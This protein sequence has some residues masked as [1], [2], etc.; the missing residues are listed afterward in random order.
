MNA[1][2][3]LR[4][5]DAG[6]LQQ[7]AEINRVL[8]GARAALT[9]LELWVVHPDP[10]PENLP[11]MDFPLAGIR[12][13]ALEPIHCSET[14]LELLRHLMDR[15]P[16]D[17]VLFPSSGW[18]AEMATRAAFRAAGCAGLQVESCD[19]SADRLEIQKPVYGS[20]LSAR[21]AMN[22]R[23]CCLAVAKQPCPPARPEPLKGVDVET[24]Q[25]TQSHP[26]RTRV[27]KTI[28]DP[29][30]AGLADALRVLVVGQGA[31]SRET[32][33]LLRG[34]ADAL[35]FELGASRPVVMNAWV[36]M[37]RLIGTSGSII[38]PRL[39]IAAGVS[40]AGVFSVGIRSSKLIVAVNTDPLA[41]IFQ[42]ADVGIVRELKAFLTDLV[43]VIK[44][45]ETVRTGNGA[46]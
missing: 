31:G 24:I 33:D 22:Q 23:P 44:T 20:N 42:I 14:C 1:A 30:P 38:S 10:P 17:L 39:C 16:M 26:A 19:V 13:A 28:P 7:A 34:V 25:W 35:G 12:L 43:D 15:N 3:V 29:P 2:I 46:P 11:A 6:M 41:P 27:V 9:R 4:A 8:E 21:F 36:P 40:G 18:G 45:G 5:D 32:V 37:N